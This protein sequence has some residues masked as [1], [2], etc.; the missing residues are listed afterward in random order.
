MR[1]A[2]GRNASFARGQLNE[3]SPWTTKVAGCSQHKETL[4]K[5]YGWQKRLSQHQAKITALEVVW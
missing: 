1:A 4:M 3:F 2:T 5:L